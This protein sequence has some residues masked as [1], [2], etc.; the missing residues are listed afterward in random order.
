MT[1]EEIAKSL[2]EQNKDA[3]L[4]LQAGE[5]EKAYAAFGVYLN[6][7]ITYKLYDYAAKARINMANTLYIIAYPGRN[8]AQ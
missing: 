3:V 8:Q 7:L 4:L 2:K 6:N 1:S 5:Y